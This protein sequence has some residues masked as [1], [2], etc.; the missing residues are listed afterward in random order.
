MFEFSACIE[1]LVPHIDFYDRFEKAKL[2]GFNAV[3]FWGWEDKD[4]SRIK[5][6]CSSLDL[7]V[8]SISGDGA[9]FSLCDDAHMHGYLEYA[10]RSMEA[11][12]QIDCSMIVIHS[13]ALGENGVVID[14]YER[15]SPARKRMNMLRTLE[16][17]A[18]LAEEYEVTCVLEP[19]NTY[20][21]HPG[22]AL[23]SIDDAA[24]ITR[25][26][27]SRRIK[28]LY[29]MYH[30]QIMNGDLIR[31]LERNIDQIGHIHIADNPGRSEPGTG[32]I[33]YTR[34][35]EK[36][37]ELDFVPFV[38]FE[39]APATTFEAAVSSIIALK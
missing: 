16:K 24:E 21:D 32:E 35:M 11:A 31:T 22:N 23:H 29:D 20:V 37:K 12:K 9:Q 1:I 17:L 30:M 8:S 3:E 4:L 2:A 13:N 15:F 27:G 14:H 19:L 7:T 5:T 25:L 18:P 33:N 28:V 36:L 39:L 26:I 34:I 38:A 10:I 6:I